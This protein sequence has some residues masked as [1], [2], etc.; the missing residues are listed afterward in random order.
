MKCEQVL[1]LLGQI[2]EGKRPAR[3]ASYQP[4]L[5]RGLVETFDTYLAAL[6]QA[7]RVLEQED[8]IKLDGT[9]PVT[10]RYLKRLRTLEADLR[11]DLYRATTGS[12]KLWQ[13]ERTRAH[14]LPLVGALQ[15][16]ELSARLQQQLQRDQAGAP[17]I[18]CEDAPFVLALTPRGQRVGH[19]LH[20]KIGRFQG[21]S[22]DDFLK[23]LDKSDAALEQLAHNAAQLNGALASVP[24]GRHHVVTG[25]LKSGLPPQQALQAFQQG[26]QLNRLGEK[27]EPPQLATALVRSATQERHELHLEAQRLAQAVGLLAQRYGNTPAVR[28]A[29]KTLLPFPDLRAGLARFDQLRGGLLHLRFDP[30]EALKGAAR[31]MGLKATENDLL[32]RVNAALHLAYQ[33]PLRQH[34]R[35]DWSALV[36]AA[37]APDLAAVPA[38]HQRLLELSQAYTRHKLPHNTKPHDLALDGLGCPGTPPEVAATILRIAERLARQEQRAVDRPHLDMASAFAR[39]ITF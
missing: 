15:G 35:R 13:Q 11:S 2:H 1:P 16:T 3:L 6:A 26:M 4:L 18:P 37:T 33:G 24:R 30:E 29:A 31:L 5:A 14:L 23:R 19:A 7:V 17:R 27:N 22:I 32:Q 25:L 21:K 9:L 12:A 36:V 28:G 39:Q 38:M 8:K 34:P 20:E 10:A